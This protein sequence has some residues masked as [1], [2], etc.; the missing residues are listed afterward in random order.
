ML[1]QESALAQ[2]SSRLEEVTRQNER[3]ASRQSR[4]RYSM[5]LTWVGGAL[6]VS[7][8]AG[9][10]GGLWW[11]DYRSRKRHGGFRIY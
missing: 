10:L 9:F 5:P 1:E 4:Y 6:S 2:S 8:L 7:L 11:L 3:Y